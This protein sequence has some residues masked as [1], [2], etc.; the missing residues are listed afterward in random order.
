MNSQTIYSDSYIDYHVWTIAIA[1]PDA[2]QRTI[3]RFCNRQD[4][5]DHLRVLR[6]FVPSAQFE[7]VFNP[8]E[9]ASFDNAIAQG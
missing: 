1:L 2:R 7:I 8:P 5:E 9:P 4:A 3:A 6:R